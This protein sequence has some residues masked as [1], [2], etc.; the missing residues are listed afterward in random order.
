MK[1]G[2][3]W[4][5]A[6]AVCL[7]LS[8]C[9]MGEA[10]GDNTVAGNQ[11]LSEGSYEEA[12]SLFQEAQAQGETAVL[13]L[14]GEGLACMGL[15]RY[16]EAEQAFQEALD[17]ADDKMPENTKDIRLYLA[18]AQYRQD[19]YEDAISTCDDILEEETS[20]ADARFIRGASSLFLGNESDAKRDFDAAAAAAPEDYDLFLNIY[21]CYAQISQSA[22][23]DEYL[24]QALTIQ[25]E[26]AEHYYNRGRIYYYLENY[27]EAENQLLVPV[28]E[29]YEPAM[30][31]MGQVYLAQGDY[32]RG[33]GIYQQIQS[34]F[35][36]SAA[37]YN[38]LAQCSL[39]EGD[40]DMALSYIAQGLAL[41][42]NEGKQ[43]LYFNEIVAY[44]RKQ[45]FDTAKTKAEEYVSRYPSDEAGQKEWEFLSTR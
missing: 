38:G 15:G 10:T 42:G 18:T 29:K 6:A 28:D 26:D 2:V 45:D 16:E 37:C 24:E 1:R 34:E 31:L 33:A 23:G 13:A 17:A 43:E 25:G 5:A 11:A 36:E 44:E 12:L 4:A 14:R 20:D 9:T 39:A 8:G 27:T 21:E 3:L 7:L 35:G 30:Y 40:Y 41:D 32:A 19:K 22:V